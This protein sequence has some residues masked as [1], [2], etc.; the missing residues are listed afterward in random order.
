MKPNRRHAALAA[1]SLLWAGLGIFCAR[2]AMEAFIS[3]PLPKST[4]Q[5]PMHAR[6]D[7]ESVSK[8]LSPSIKPAAAA[9]APLLVT[10]SLVGLAS[11]HGGQ[12]V[13]LISVAGGPS[14]PYF[15]GS[16]IAG[17]YEITS[18]SETGVALKSPQGD[19]LLEAP[20]HPSALPPL[21]SP[22][23]SAG[24]LPPMPSSPDG[25]ARFPS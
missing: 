11:S 10:L 15:V 8:A 17:A 14:R 13:A 9:Q 20:K 21:P 12:G 22:L 19:Q 3:A 16:T 18:I 23:N 1:T 25:A 2:A 5:A 24:R 6:I 7:S 4:P